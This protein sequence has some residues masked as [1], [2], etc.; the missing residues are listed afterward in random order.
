MTQEVVVTDS[1]RLENRGKRDTDRLIRNLIQCDT[2]VLCFP[3]SWEVENRSR[4]VDLN[5][6]GRGR[7]THRLATSY[8][9]YGSAD[10]SSLLLSPTLLLSVHKLYLGMQH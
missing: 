1:A 5:T 8:L 3:T 7:N 4:E 6:V 9:E 2:H 10:S